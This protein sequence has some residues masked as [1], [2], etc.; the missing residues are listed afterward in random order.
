MAEVPEK[1][2]TAFWADRLKDPA[3]KEWVER[4]CKQTV[5]DGLWGV[6]P[7]GR[8]YSKEEV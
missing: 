8:Y 1:D 5:E 4:M 7:E 6:D 3:L 2:D